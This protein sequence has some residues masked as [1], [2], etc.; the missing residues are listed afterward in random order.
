MNFQL[1][2]GTK[3]V[4]FLS[5]GVIFVSRFAFLLYQMGFIFASIVLGMALPY[6]TTIIYICIVH[7]ACRFN[8][9]GWAQWN[10]SFHLLKRVKIKFS[11][12]TK[13]IMFVLDQKLIQLSKKVRHRPFIWFIRDCVIPSRIIWILLSKNL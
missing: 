7:G 10:Y 12:L 6:A 2:K 9:L 11:I 4:L 13:K 1:F 3:Y 5:G 8:I